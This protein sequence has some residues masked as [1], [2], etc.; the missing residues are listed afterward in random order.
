MLSG[1]A[2]P[3][4]P[5]GKGTESPP[6]PDE[7]KKSLES[8][9]KEDKTQKENAPGEVAENEPNAHS[10][11]LD[12]K[13]KEP[14]E[15]SSTDAIPVA[16]I[17]EQAVIIP[18]Q[19]LQVQATAN[20]IVK[21][22]IPTST[23][24]SEVTSVS[25]NIASMLNKGEDI[26][27]I[28]LE[29]LAAT[30]G[31]A[32]QSIL[33]AL[34]SNAP[35]EPVTL[36]QVKIDQQSSPKPAVQPQTAPE[37]A[38]VNQLAKDLN[39]KTVQLSQ[40]PTAETAV[41][42]TQPTKTD[43][44]ISTEKGTAIKSETTGIEKAD[45]KL[46]SVEPKTQTDSQDATF[47][48]STSSDDSKKDDSKSLTSTE[49]VISASAPTAT[50]TVEAP[51]AETKVG[52]L[53]SA[54]RQKIVDSVSQKIDELS[55]RSVRNEVRV[56]MMPA[57]MG[58]VIVNVRKSLDGLTATL[59]ATNEPLRQALHDSRNDLAGALA[60]RNVGQIRVEVRSANADTMNMGQ[61]FNQ[62]HSQS[63]QQQQHQQQLHKQA[64][65]NLA[66]AN[67]ESDPRTSVSANR[68]SRAAANSTAL[69]ME[70]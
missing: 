43:A 26:G 54:N 34:K 22:A 19:F 30:F 50:S 33:G 32:N 7:F 60:D 11:K 38:V 41:V 63:Q 10:Q 35:A 39:V 15:A 17:A 46:V 51:K 25:N 20:P 40:T 9:T 4:A 49:N 55:V 44:T 18:I 12:S 61:Q 29:A 52:H 24:N 62:A 66:T 23:E 27:D 3:L 70:I 45:P 57:E 28:N 59:S 67:R 36:G 58:T 47:G 68:P 14:K 48:Q 37:A 53:D 13:D 64:V 69:D 5:P 31:K 42:A 16:V 56:E 1:G 2:A 6:P 8:A 65:A 21:A